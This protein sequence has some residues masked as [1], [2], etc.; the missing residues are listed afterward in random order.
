MMMAVR[1]HDCVLFATNIVLADTTT[2]YGKA[3]QCMT[4]VMGLQGVWVTGNCEVV[5][6]LETEKKE[7]GLAST[8]QAKGNLCQGIGR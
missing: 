7:W 8:Q 5:G 4:G 3:I 6:I 2:R 1:E